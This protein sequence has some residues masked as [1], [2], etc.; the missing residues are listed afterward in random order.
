MPLI[1][2]KPLDC[3][4][5]IQCFEKV[6]IYHDFLLKTIAKINDGNKE[7]ILGSRQSLMT[8]QILS[9]AGVEICTFSDDHRNAGNNFVSGLDKHN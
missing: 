9:D 5:K 2:K 3:P 4:G 6:N 7:E 8:E 1:K